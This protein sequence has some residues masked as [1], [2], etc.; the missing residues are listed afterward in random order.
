M[1]SFPNTTHAQ[2][3]KPMRQWRVFFVPRTGVEWRPHPVCLGR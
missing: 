1:P 2:S 3:D